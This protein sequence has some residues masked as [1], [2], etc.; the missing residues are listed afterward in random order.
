MHNS[1]FLKNG[2]RSFLESLRLITAFPA[3]FTAWTW[4]T[5]LAVS[6]PIMVMLIAGGSFVQVLTTR[7]MA[8]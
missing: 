6:R 5:D 3:S 7:T 1:C 4:K 2:I 8:H